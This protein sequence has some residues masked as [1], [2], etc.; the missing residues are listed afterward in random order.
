MKFFSRL[1]TCVAC[2]KTALLVQFFF[3]SAIAQTEG[4]GQ[5]GVN[6][7]EG[8]PSHPSVFEGIRQTL[9]RDLEKATGQKVVDLSTSSSENI[10]TEVFLFVQDQID[11]TQVVI[12][13]QDK[14]TGYNLNHTAVRGQIQQIGPFQNQLTFTLLGAL[15]LRIDPSKMAELQKGHTSQIGA[16]QLVGSAQSAFRQ[17]KPT[18]ALS[19][20]SQARSLDPNFEAPIN[21]LNVKGKEHLSR[22][23]S[24]DDIA[25]VYLNLGQW[26]QAL[27]EFD[28]ALNQNPNSTKAML[29]KA[30]VFLKTQKINDAIVLL[31]KI[32]TLDVAH[33][34]AFALLGQAL[35]KAGKSPQALVA[36]Q[37]A[38]ALGYQ[39][40]ETYGDLGSIY[41]RQGQAPLA[42]S[43]YRRAG[44]MS[45]KTVNF[46]QAGDF[47]ELSNKLNP[48]ANTLIAQV[49]SLLNAGE[50]DVAITVINKGLIVYSN[51]D[52]LIA[53]MGRAFLAKR[54]GTQAQLRFKKALELN[55]QNYDANFYLG[56]ILKDIEHAQADAIKHFQVASKINPNAIEPRLLLAQLLN[57]KEKFEE[58]RQILEELVKLKPNHLDVL[59]SLG[60]A[61]LKIA[62]YAQAQKTFEKALEI[63]S[64][65][66]EANENLAKVFILSGQNKRI[67]PQIDIVF[68]INAINNIFTRPDGLSLLSSLTPKELLQTVL[69]FPKYISAAGLD[70]PVNHV[71]LSK[72][73]T[74]NSWLKKILSKF[75]LF[76]INKDRIERDI[77][78]ALF[79]QY[80]VIRPQNSIALSFDNIDDAQFKDSAFMDGLSRGKNLDGYV[81]YTTTRAKSDGK[82]DALVVDFLL[83]TVRDGGLHGIS[84]KATLEAIHYPKREIYSFNFDC[85]KYYGAVILFII[86]PLASLIYLRVR[87]RGWGDVKVTI[88]YDPSMESFLTLKLST[89]EEKQQTSDK[90]IV[91]DKDKSKKAKYKKLLKQKGAWVKEMVGKETIFNKVPAKAYY[92]YLYGTIEEKGFTKA[93]VGNYFMVQKIQVQKNQT[94]ELLFQLIRE[95]AFVTVVVTLGEEAV[96]GAS[97]NIKGIPDTHYTRGAEGTFFYLKPGEY[98]LTLTYKEKKHTQKINITN[99]DDIH[100]QYDLSTLQDVLN[101]QSDTELLETAKE[102]EEQGRKDDAAQI[103][104]K[105]GDT[106]KA[107]ETKAESLLEEGDSHGA[108]EQLIKAKEFLRAAQIY[109]TL[110][111]PQNVS[112]MY[113]YHAV[114][115]K[116]SNKAIQYFEKAKALEPLAKLYQSMGEH[117]K[118]HIT[119]AQIALQKGQKIEAAQNYIKAEDFARA[120]EIYEDLKEPQKAAAL[121]AKDGNYS[122]A[123]NLF[124]SIGDKPKAALAFE[125]AGEYDQAILMYQELGNIQ[126]VLELYLLTDNFLQAAQLAQNQG[127]FDK[128]I[129]IAQKTPPHSSQYKQS[130]VLLAALLHAKGQYDLSLS[131]Y[132]DLYQ[133]NFNLLTLEDRYIYGELLEYDQNFPVAL[134]VFETLAKQNLHFKDVGQKIKTLKDKVKQT[135]QKPNVDLMA[136]TIA[137]NMPVESRYEILEELGRGAMGI[138][139]KAKDKKLD[140]IVAFKTLPHA[141]QND[142]EALS[143]LKQEALTAAKLTHPNIVTVYDVGQEGKDTYISMEYVQGKTLQQ[144]LKTI[145]KVKPGDFSSIATPLCQA[146]SYAHENKVIHRDI[147]PS[148]I[149]LVPQNKSVKLMDFGLAKV[150][151]DLSI[152]KTMLR[153]TPLYM[154]PEQ[155]LGQN[156]DHRTD[157][158]ALGILFYECLTGAPPF[159]TGDIMYAHLHTKPKPILEVDPT[160]PQKL[161]EIIMKCIEKD[162]N[163]RPNDAKEI[164][165]TL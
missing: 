20:L 114:Q 154:S 138:V 118:H 119:L 140:R 56:M 14:P 121:Y 129:D 47:F 31:E 142:K 155:I 71:A 58:A 2:S 42:S 43:A 50:P 157:I 109:E 160:L 6:A 70:F 39:S 10:K 148:N 162:K 67:I 132:T 128:A 45:N 130:Q 29:G 152:D 106:Q 51:N 7:F 53:L 27:K 22:L 153:G 139:S 89:K 13:V 16:L 136:S 156:I 69:K 101:S 73:N 21:Q 4:L 1:T 78:V 86:L 95:E 103:Y 12:R 36:T 124:A 112:L 79:S 164:I 80:R 30:K 146:V 165:Q 61:Y 113:G 83:H 92:C 104:E 75:S 37:K 117:K 81:G 46:R 99:I 77:V 135:S 91:R 110:G 19:A 120:A 108:I 11:E 144:I 84:D 62:D 98:L 23:R 159:T 88:N 149:I 94:T 143:L 134:N 105:V 93:T 17:E 82:T 163:L 41:L 102:Y 127:L 59:L 137:G 5:I 34:E 151:Q 125:K 65:H 54:E 150:L 131:I 60:E 8:Q 52:Q 38:I 48:N 116:D 161:A 107:M 32:T 76:A 26:E 63:F 123:G 15:G 90:L 158:Y 9:I 122:M 74:E 55:P 35:E 85:L 147:K 141:L 133:N 25:E 72:I 57:Q 40:S 145:R 87:K 111:E 44:E 100:L 97:V 18:L 64:N 68:S 96:T 28:R 24:A 115:N 33:G 126:K 49:E 3:F 66:L